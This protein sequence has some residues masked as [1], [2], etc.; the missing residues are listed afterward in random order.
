MPTPNKQ[1]GT[2]PIVRPKAAAERDALAVWIDTA[3]LHVAG[4]AAAGAAAMLRVGVLHHQRGVYSFAYDRAW[5][6][7]KQRF[8]LDPDLSLHAGEQFSATGGNF[9]IFLD[10]APDRWGRLLME[11]RESI[12]AASEGRAPRV[13]REWDF[14]CGVQDI[15]RMGALRF[16]ANITAANADDTMPFVANDLF[17]VP[18]V[19]SL[20]QLQAVSFAV[21]A[22]DERASTKKD[23]LLRDWLAQ[24]VAP[25]S[26][27]GGARPKANF[28][29]PDGSLWIAKFP[30]REDRRNVAGWEMVLHTLAAKAGIDVPTAQLLHLHQDGTSI[31]RN[32]SYPSFCVQRFDRVGRE[33]KLFVSA[34]TLLGATDG[35]ATHSYLDLAD[36]VAREGAAGCVERDLEQLF[37]RVLFNVMVCNRDDHLRNHGFIRAASG[38]RLSPA[39][40]MNPNPE[41]YEHAL[42]VAPGIAAPQVRDV[43]NTA[44]H[45]RIG[46]EK[47]IT[48][49]TAVG[50]VVRGWKAAAKR[51]GVGQGAGD[52]AI[53][54]AISAMLSERE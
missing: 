22:N 23:A 10:S 39:Y 24:L 32:A 40:D 38:W 54:A 17:A 53:G 36:F 41:K 14:L 30:S 49:A 28:L 26:S 20:A 16:S 9:R 13:L 48:L 21:E 51:L 31:E 25:G 8:L 50:S 52:A 46:A 35:A 7:S 11:R 37:R 3:A 4:E 6:E 2:K 33:R 15:T 5:L 43:V 18:P 29:Q 47:A 42:A 45:Y 27:L 44:Q 12:A 34:M 1:R 19:T